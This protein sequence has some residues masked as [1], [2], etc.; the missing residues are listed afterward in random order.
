MDEQGIEPWT[1]RSCDVCAS[2]Q[3]EHYTTKPHALI[4]T[5]ESSLAA[6]EVIKSM[7]SIDIESNLWRA[8][9]ICCVL[10]CFHPYLFGRD[11]DRIYLTH[12][13]TTDGLMCWGF[14]WKIESTRT[15]SP[16]VIFLIFLQIRGHIAIHMYI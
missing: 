2:V 4:D 15:N 9:N 13:V 10:V 11:N 14:A 5:I 1:S 7:K 8:S 12:T 16:Y 6:L 3:S